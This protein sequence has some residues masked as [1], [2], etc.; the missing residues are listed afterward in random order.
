M[1]GTI[2]EKSFRNLHKKYETERRKLKVTN[3]SGAGVTASNLETNRDEKLVQEDNGEEQEKDDH[4]VAVALVQSNESVAITNP[5][6]PADSPSSAKILSVTGRPQ[7]IK[8]NKRKDESEMETDLIVKLKE[9]LNSKK[10]EDGLYGN[11]LA[12]KLR[13]L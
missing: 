12:T 2:A 4:N 5:K 7:L 3:R 8:R 1:L 10:D 6:I 11:L 9:K 13:S